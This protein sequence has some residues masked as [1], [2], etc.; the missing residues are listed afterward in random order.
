M[1]I[2]MVIIELT[3]HCKQEM[4]EDKTETRDREANRSTSSFTKSGNFTLPEF[5][6][7]RH[8]F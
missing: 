4:E 5:A 8:R 3:I 2:T 7:P 6:A 1:R